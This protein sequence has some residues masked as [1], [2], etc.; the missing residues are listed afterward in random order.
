LLFRDY[1][2]EPTI[3]KRTGH[4]ETEQRNEQ[5]TDENFQQ[6]IALWFENEE[7]EYRWRFGHISDWNTSCDQ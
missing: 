5:L 2:H 1:A 6:A 4:R 3:R 7:E